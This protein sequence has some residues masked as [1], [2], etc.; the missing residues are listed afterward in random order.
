MY[1]RRRNFVFGS[2]SQLSIS[3]HEVTRFIGGQALCSIS[4][5]AK[6]LELRIVLPYQQTCART[7]GR[8]EMI[9]ALLK[10]SL[11]HQQ[12]LQMQEQKAREEAHQGAQHIRTRVMAY[13]LTNLVLALT[14]Q[15]RV[16][17]LLYSQRGYVLPFHIGVDLFLNKKCLDSA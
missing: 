4:F 16:E 2:P 9:A 12:L 1:S 17:I 8:Q 7:C 10:S 5:R 3:S 14:T 6:E 13:L 15:V 11:K